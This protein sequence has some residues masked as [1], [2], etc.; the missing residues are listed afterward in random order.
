MDQ[1]VLVAAVAVVLAFL[2]DLALLKN[3]VVVLVAAVVVLPV[4]ERRGSN[5]YTLCDQSELQLLAC[6]CFGESLRSEEWFDFERLKP[7]WLEPKWLRSYLAFAVSS[8]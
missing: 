7:K 1:V 3:L 8:Y 2:D 5:K 4:S 6:S